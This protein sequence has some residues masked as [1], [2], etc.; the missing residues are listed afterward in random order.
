MVR[1]ILCFQHLH[2]YLFNTPKEGIGLTVYHRLLLREVL[3][4]RNALFCP[5]LVAKDILYLIGFSDGD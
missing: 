5:V 4:H 2:F 1:L 3:L